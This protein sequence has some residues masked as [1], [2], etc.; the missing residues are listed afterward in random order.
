MYR[1][2]QNKHLLYRDL[3]QNDIYLKV[4]KTLVNGLA[5]VARADIAD[6]DYASAIEVADKGLAVLPDEATLSELKETAVKQSTRR[7][8]M[9]GF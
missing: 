2:S 4:E 7:R 1:V 3:Y 5:E 8:P 9:G 6:K